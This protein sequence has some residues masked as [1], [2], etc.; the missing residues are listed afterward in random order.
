MGGEVE[1]EERES[2]DGGCDGDVFFCNVTAEAAEEL[3]ARANSAVSS[4]DYKKGPPLRRESAPG[5]A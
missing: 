2:E 1:A 3:N 4:A 5:G